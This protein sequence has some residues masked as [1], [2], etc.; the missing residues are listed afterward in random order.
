MSGYLRPC[1]AGISSSWADHKNRN[2]PSGEPGTDYAC[3]YG[4]QILAAEDGTVV[5]YS[6]STGGGTGRYL[7]IDLDDGR[8]VRYLHLSE[9][10]LEVGAR[11]GRGWHVATSGASAW[12][13]DWGVGAHVHTTLFPGHSYDFGNTLDFEAHA[14]SDDEGDDEL[15]ATQADQLNNIYN[16]IF[17]GGP[18]MP[19]GNRSLGQSIADLAGGQR[20][21][22]YRTVDGAP[23]ETSWIQE[24]AD[25]KTLALEDK[26]R[27]TA[28]PT[29]R[30]RSHRG[31]LVVPAWAGAGILA[32]VAIVEIIRLIIENAPPV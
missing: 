32:V 11:V 7:T 26:E 18:S 29:K 15:N 22:V 25:V 16:A 5:D 2:P 27:E 24:L 28:P 21:I 9:T 13:S 31:D 8:R 23:T 10:W 14:G 19:D 17:Y 30:D 6:R 3:G 4:T 12:G 20:P 1:D